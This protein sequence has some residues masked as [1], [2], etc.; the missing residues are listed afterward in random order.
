MKLASLINLKEQNTRSGEFNV[1]VPV[2]DV[3]TKVKIK[4]GHATGPV[5]DVTISWGDE[6]HTV[7]FEQTKESYGDSQDY[8]EP[9]TWI[10]EAYSEDNMWKFTVEVMKDPNENAD[11]IWDVEWETLKISVDDSKLGGAMDDDDV[12]RAL[13]VDA[14]D[15]SLQEQFQRLAGIRP[16]YEQSFDD[17]LKAAGGFSDEEFASMTAT[18]PN[19]FMD[20]DDDRSPGEELADRTI[21]EFSKK[22]FSSSLCCC[23]I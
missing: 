6:S 3:D 1:E 23:I 15:K 18:D 20:D 11:E 10:Y 5:D 9:E 13:T 19:P 21:E 17:R 8:D 14:P 16:L 12:D 22:Y 2:Q 7:D 4:Y